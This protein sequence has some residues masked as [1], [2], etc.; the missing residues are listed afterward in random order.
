MP[1]FS[2]PADSVACWRKRKRDYEDTTSLARPYVDLGAFWANMSIRVPSVTNCVLFTGQP[3]FPSGEIVQSSRAATLCRCLNIRSTIPTSPFVLFVSLANANTSRALM[4]LYPLRDHHTT[5]H[6]T[7]TRLL[8][9]LTL[10][11]FPRRPWCRSPILPPR[12]RSSG[13][14]TYA[15]DGLQHAKYSML[16]Q[17]VSSVASERVL[18]AC[19]NVI[20][21]LVLARSLKG[22]STGTPAHNERSAPAVQSR[23][24]P[25]LG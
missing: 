2:E 3:S 10:R 13:L 17:T 21:W 24:L 18:F 22:F 15:T 5:S 7:F 9:T 25:I 1:S 4:S 14:V 19:V 8:K 23:V 12:L 16:M 11:L 6:Q 20:H